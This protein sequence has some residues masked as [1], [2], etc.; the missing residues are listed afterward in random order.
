MV[1]IDSGSDVTFCGVSWADAG[2]SS[3]IG[4]DVDVVSAH[5]PRAQKSDGVCAA[6]WAAH[7]PYVKLY[8]QEGLRAD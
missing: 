3:G 4:P 7:G 6:C 1:H 2:M 8:Q 5:D